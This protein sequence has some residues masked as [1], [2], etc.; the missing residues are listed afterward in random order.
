MGYKP[1]C[2]YLNTD[3]PFAEV[4]LEWDCKDPKGRLDEI[5]EDKATHELVML[6]E[7]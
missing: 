5:V 2:K 6:R 4:T 3:N 1:F 7:V